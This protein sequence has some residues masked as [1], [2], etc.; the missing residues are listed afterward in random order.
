[1]HP[2]IIPMDEAYPAYCVVAVES[3]GRQVP[4]AFLERVKEDFNKR[5]GGGKAATATANS[6]NREFGY[7][8]VFVFL[9]D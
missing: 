4:I 5:Y 8:A 9:V 1:P 3:A 6:L 7:L 2:L